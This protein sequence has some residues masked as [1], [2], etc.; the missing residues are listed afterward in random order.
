MPSVKWRHVL[1]PFYCLYS[2]Q[3]A[4]R[5]RFSALFCFLFFSIFATKKMPYFLATEKAVPDPRHVRFIN[6]FPRVTMR[7]VETRSTLLYIS[8][9]ELI[10]CYL[11]VHIHFL[12]ICCGSYRLI[13]KL[14]FTS[15]GIFV[16]N[17]CQ[18]NSYIRKLRNRV[19]WR[20]I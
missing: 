7:R 16:N 17:L 5:V 10:L 6:F 13:D 15:L 20:A 4:Q 18:L 9:H 12:I 14:T 2:R 11:R 3:K 8:Y 19:S 1:H